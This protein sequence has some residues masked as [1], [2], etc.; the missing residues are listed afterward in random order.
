MASLFPSRAHHPLPDTL[1]AALSGALGAGGMNGQSAIRTAAEE[2]PGCV[3]SPS[4]LLT[5]RSRMVARAR[6]TGAE[7]TDGP[8]V[9]PRQGRGDAEALRGAEEVTG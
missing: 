6:Q 5:L 3:A 7:A 9:Y 4:P 8:G 1:R 2:W